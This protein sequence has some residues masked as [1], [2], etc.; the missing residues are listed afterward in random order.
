MSSR[1]VGIY[2]LQAAIAAE[3]ARAPAA[4]ATDWRQIVALYDAL[5]EIS[6]SPIIELNRAVAVAMRDGPDAGLSHHGEHWVS[7]LGYPVTV[8][9]NF[10]RV[11]DF[12]SR[13]STIG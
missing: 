12:D 11:V 1:R 4:S 2:S 7:W 10:H 13:R 8:R 6:P 5:L 3:H 9:K